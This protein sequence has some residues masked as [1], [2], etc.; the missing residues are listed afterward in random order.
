VDFVGKKKSM[1]KDYLK[2]MWRKIK[3]LEI[4]EDVILGL[5]VWRVY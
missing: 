3:L 5:G 2:M 4:R 1:S